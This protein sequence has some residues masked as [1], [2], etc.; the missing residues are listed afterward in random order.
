MSTTGKKR[1]KDRILDAALEM[2]NAEGE[3]NVT[4]NALADELD[5]SPGNLHYHFKT[6]AHLVE[7][8]FMRFE[9]E[10]SEILNVGDEDLVDLVVAWMKLTLLFETMWSHRFVYRDLSQLLAKYPSLQRKMASLLHEKISLAQQGCE[11][12]GIDPQEADTAALARNT[13]VVMTYWISFES[14]CG[15]E[16]DE[17][18][19]FGRGCYQVT[20]LLLPYLDEQANVTLQELAGEFISG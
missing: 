11:M 3:P 14:A 12:L 8:L 7:A 18:S 2:F 19:R 20:V 16:G 5:I 6:K 17:R 10:V 9:R 15:V 1:T 13:V 4:T